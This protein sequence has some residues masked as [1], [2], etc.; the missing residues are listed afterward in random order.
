[1]FLRVRHQK[2]VYV[3]LIVLMILGVSAVLGAMITY[4]ALLREQNFQIQAAVAKLASG[5]VNN[6][7]FGKCIK[8]C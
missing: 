6:Q 5:D 8:E 1:M 4:N 3:Y 7:R 2:I